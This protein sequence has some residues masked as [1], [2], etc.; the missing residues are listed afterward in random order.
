M[1][2]FGQ[3]V[4]CM[5]TRLISG[6]TLCGTTAIGGPVVVAVVVGRTRGRYGRA[7][8]SADDEVPVGVRQCRA[9]DALGFALKSVHH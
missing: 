7:G 9:L 5:D 2:R 4:Q 6:P 1:I 3:N 8:P